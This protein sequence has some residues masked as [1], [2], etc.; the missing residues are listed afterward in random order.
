[1]SKGLKRLRFPGKQ[2]P[3]R[4]RVR[5]GKNSFKTAF[6]SGRNPKKVAKGADGG[7]ILSVTKV[8]MEE[9]LKVGSFFQLGKQLMEEFRKEE[10]NGRGEESRGE[11]QG[12]PS[13][14][15]SD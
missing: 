8:S 9:L 5:E 4:V 11:G 6:L 10:N 12:L 7:R 14:T 15:G 1:M 3:Y 2:V 13:T